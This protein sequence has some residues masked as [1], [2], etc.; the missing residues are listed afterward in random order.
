[1]RPV[2]NGDAIGEIDEVVAC[3]KDAAKAF[4]LA[5]RA[6]GVRQARLLR[7]PTLGQRCYARA[8]VV[9]L[10]IRP[11]TLVDHVT[12]SVPEPTS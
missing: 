2:K 7:E 12:G 10:P 8:V 5:Y 6:A 3:P 4:A 1:M 11:D 9:F